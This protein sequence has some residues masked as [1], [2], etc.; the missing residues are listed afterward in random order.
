MQTNFPTVAITEGD[1]LVSLKSLICSKYQPLPQFFNGLY[2]F[3]DLYRF[4]STESL[5]V[6]ISLINF[7]CISR[8]FRGAK[9]KNFRGSIPPNNPPQ[10]THLYLFV[11]QA[12]LH[13]S[14]RKLAAVGSQIGTDTIIFCLKTI[15]C[16]RDTK[17]RYRC[18]L[19]RFLREEVVKSFSSTLAFLQRFRPSTPDYRK[20]IRK[21]P[22]C[23]FNWDMP[24]PVT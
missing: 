19:P 3:V 16:V 1:I 18:N 9:I 6:R 21:H 4:L 5:Y 24:M 15:K 23:F 22:F 8:H 17:I 11:F 12:P 10:L 20:R 2:H 7:E 13:P 14:T